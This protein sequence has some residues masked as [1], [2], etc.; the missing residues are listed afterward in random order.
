MVY[1]NG[2]TTHGHQFFLKDNI[3]LDELLPTLAQSFEIESPGNIRLFNFQG[4]EIF[5]QDLRFLRNR[6]VIYL[7]EGI[8][9]FI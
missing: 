3:R 7:S 1:K 5:E 4:L 2:D 6:D 9:S 8:C